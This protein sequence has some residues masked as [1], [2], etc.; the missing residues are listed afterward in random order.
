MRWVNQTIGEFGQNIGIPGMS[1]AEGGELQLVAD[2]GSSIG[3]I[4]ARELH[5]PQ[6]IVFRAVS[7][8]YLT[9]SQLKKAMQLAN[10]RHPRPWQVQAAC[11]DKHLFIAIR[12]PERAFITSSLEEGLEILGSLVKALENS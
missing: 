6:M 10:F 8:D 2:D 1:L 3:L 11:S 7:I 12:F 4:H 5:M 9:V